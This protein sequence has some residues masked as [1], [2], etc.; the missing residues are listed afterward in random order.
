M[1]HYCKRQSPNFSY[2]VRVAGIRDGT[3]EHVL[4][5]SIGHNVRA[6]FTSGAAGWEFVL[7][8]SVQFASGKGREYFCQIVKASEREKWRSNGTLEQ[9]R[10]RYERLICSLPAVRWSN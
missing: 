5:P 3:A 2:A 9:R 8:R 1:L 7:S 4:P 10:T 6:R